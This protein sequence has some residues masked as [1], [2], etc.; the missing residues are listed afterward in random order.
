[1]KAI[2]FDLDGVLVETPNVHFESLNKSLGLFGYSISAEEHAK[3]YNGLPTKTKLEMLGI[4]NALRPFI[5][6]MKNKYTTEMIERVVKPDYQKIMMC[7][8]LEKRYTL[9]V[10]SNATHKSCEHV[11]NACGLIEFMS[12]IIGNDDVKNA[13]PN[14]E[15][16]RKAFKVLGYQPSECVVLE[17]APY[18]IQAARASGARVIETTYKDVNSALFI[19]EG[20]LSTTP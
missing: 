9:A 10:A 13:K 2:I 20:L 16:Y 3:T 7:N 1:M 8:S 15:I 18:G 5:V 14:P 11:L 4:P 12:Y 17:D 6:E 19:R